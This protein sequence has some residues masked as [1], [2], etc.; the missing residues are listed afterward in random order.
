MSDTKYLIKRHQTW[1]LQLLI[2]KQLRTLYNQTKIVVSLQTT[3]LQQARL[4]RDIQVGQYRAKFQFRLKQIANLGQSSGSYTQDIL[5]CRKE[6]D[7]GLHGSDRDSLLEGLEI[8]INNDLEN[9]LRP[10]GEGVKGLVLDPDTGYRTDVDQNKLDQ[11]TLANKIVSSPTEIYLLSTALDDHIQEAKII[12]QT[13]NTRRKRVTA[14]I[15]WLGDKEI[16]KVSKFNAGDY[17]TRKVMPM[18]LAIRTKRLLIGDI[19]AFFTW[20][21]DRG[22]RRDNPFLGLTR[23]IKET[24]RGT[25]EKANSDRRA[26]TDDELLKLFRAIIDHRGTSSMLW[27]YTIIALF[28]GMRSSEIAETELEDVHDDYIHIPEGKTES[29]VR[30]VPIHKVIKPLILKLKE[31]S[32]DGYLLTQLKRGGVDDKRNHNIVKN[33]STLLRGKGGIKSK[34]VVFHCLRKNFLTALEIAGVPEP[35]AKTIAGHARDSMTYGLYSKGVKQPA[36]QEAVNMVSYNEDLE[37]LIAEHLTNATKR[38]TK[39]NKTKI[40]N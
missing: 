38:I 12:Q 24:S 32:K 16:S 33:F 22:Y 7:S 21:V 39:R 9:Y 2:P 18:D 35:T 23:G 15:N 27:P 25:K 26:F 29:S 17:I 13:K 34:Q 1:Y 6:I 19:S 37:R 14:F 30:N 4:R 3:D 36:L 20:C 31:S 8:G 40:T 5:Q 11:F 28:T 10:S